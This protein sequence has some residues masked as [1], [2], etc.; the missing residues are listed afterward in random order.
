M[1]KDAQCSSVL[2]QENEYSFQSDLEKSKKQGVARFKTS[3]KSRVN[4]T[5]TMDALLGTDID[6]VI[7]RKLR[8]GYWTVTKRRKTL[9]IQQYQLLN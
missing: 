5:P 4:W 2:T 8:V 7:A 9:G 3:S 6:S 1:S